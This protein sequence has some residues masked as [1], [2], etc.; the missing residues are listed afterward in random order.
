MKGRTL[1]L[2]KSL[3]R[4]ATFI[5]NS[6][7]LEHPRKLCR[8]L[9]RNDIEIMTPEQAMNC[10]AKRRYVVCDHALHL[11]GLESTLRG[12]TIH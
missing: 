3:P 2:L 5:W 8:Y 9:A 6:S 1:A 11:P 7:D 12:V 10:F 4:D